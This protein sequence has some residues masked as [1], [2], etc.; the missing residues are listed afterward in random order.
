VVAVGP[1]DHGQLFKTKRSMNYLMNYIQTL[2]RLR[3]RSEP[4][5]LDSRLPL[6]STTWY[7]D[8]GIWFELLKSP[9]NSIHVPHYFHS[10]TC[11]VKNKVKTINRDKGE[12]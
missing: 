4:T 12:R 11:L 6:P 3:D 10:P 8:P 2:V 9:P 7:S 1:C 5:G